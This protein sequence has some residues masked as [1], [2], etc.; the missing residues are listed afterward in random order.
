MKSKPARYGLKIFMTNDSLTWYMFNTYPYVSKS[1]KEQVEEKEWKQPAQ[2]R[3]KKKR[4]TT[5]HPPK[6]KNQSLILIKFE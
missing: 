5:T 6:K 3:R 2:T 1:E 4:E